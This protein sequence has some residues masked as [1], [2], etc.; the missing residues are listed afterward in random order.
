M[1]ENTG[2]QPISRNEAK[3]YLKIKELFDTSGAKAKKYVKSNEISFL[4]VTNYGGP[5]RTER[6]KFASKQA[7]MHRSAQ[8][9]NEAIPQAKRMFGV[10]RQQ[11]G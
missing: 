7:K 11:V 4:K 8:N 2:R 5:L 6:R 3:K 9:G 10:K 1:I